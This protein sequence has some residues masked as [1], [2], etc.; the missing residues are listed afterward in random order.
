MNTH[1]RFSAP[2]FLGLADLRPALLCWLAARHRGEQCSLP[3][4]TGLRPCA[5]DAVCDAL[6]WLGLDW[7]DGS[8]PKPLP[9]LHLPSIINHASD[10]LKSDT[11][12][13]VYIEKGYL[14]LALANHLALLGWTPRGKRELLS[15]DEL[16]ARFDPRHISRSPVPFDLPRLNWFNHRCLSRLDI[17][18]LASLLVPYLQQAYGVS[19]HAQDTG[20]APL[21]WQRVLAAAIRDELDCLAQAPDKARFAFADEIEPDAEAATV[22]AQ[23]YAPDVLRAFINELPGVTPFAYDPINDWFSALRYRF[24]ASHSMRSRDAMLVV[25]AALTGQLG[26]PCVVVVCQLLGLRRCRERAQTILSQDS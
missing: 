18:E 21:E 12:L 9:D 15:L 2:Q 5:D 1:S 24:K 11:P 3:P 7:D 20:L 16:A 13:S 10:A 19:D 23:P 8:K 4:A 14:P 26:G 17:A 22:L 6:R 25:R